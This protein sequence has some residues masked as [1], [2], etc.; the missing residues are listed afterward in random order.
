MDNH[1]VAWAAEVIQAADS[2]ALACHVAPVKYFLKKGM[3]KQACA[4]LPVKLIIAL[5]HSIFISR[6]KSITAKIIRAR[7]A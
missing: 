7:P 4:I 2:V 5:A 1:T 6:I 3:S